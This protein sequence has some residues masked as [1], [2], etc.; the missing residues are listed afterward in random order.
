MRRFMEE[1]MEAVQLTAYSGE[2]IAEK[3][4]RIVETAAQLARE[5][6]ISPDCAGVDGSR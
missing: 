3:Y 5:G 1:E 2:V 4:R 6:R